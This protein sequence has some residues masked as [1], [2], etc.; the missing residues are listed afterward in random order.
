MLGLTSNHVSKRPHV[1]IAGYTLLS[2][3]HP[4]QINAFAFEGPMPAIETY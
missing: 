2:L 1:T 3:F 4:C